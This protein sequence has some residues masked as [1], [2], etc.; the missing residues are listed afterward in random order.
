MSLLPIQVLGAG[1]LRAETTPVDE[2]TDELQ[3]L[4]DDM[5]E[6][7]HAAQ[8]IGLAAPQVGRRERL[9]VVDVEGERFVL[10]NP[11]VVDES[12]SDRAEEGC[13][14]IPE[15]YGEVERSSNIV[16]RATDREGKP[17]EIVAE[18]LLA[19]CLLH[20]IDHLHGKLFIDYLS[21][22]KRRSA[23]A[24]WELQKTKYPELLRILTPEVV[25]QLREDHEHEDERL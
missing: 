15:V 25:R 1:I 12:G 20:E 19:R 14:S 6:T 7:M 22:L 4:I 17:F 18:G 13:L 24:K 2:I 10:I 5:F 21:F 3:V 9:A 8:G 16:V 11:E 23:L